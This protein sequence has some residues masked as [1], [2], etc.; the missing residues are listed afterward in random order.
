MRHALT[1]ALCGALGAGLVRAD[2]LELAVRDR[3]TD[4]P[5]PNAYVQVGP[6]P[7]VPFVGNWGFTNASGSLTLDHQA[8][9][10]GLPLTV[11]ASGYARL[12]VLSC[13]TGSLVVWCDPAVPPQ[14]PDTSRISG[15]VRGLPITHND[16]YLDVGV[17]MGTIAPAS[18][19]SGGATGVLLSSFMDTMHVGPPVNIDV[20]VPENIDIPSQYEFF[21]VNFFKEPYTQRFRTG[22]IVD[23]ICLGYRIN[24]NDL[25]SGSPQQIAA[26]KA[27]A[28]RDY[29]VS[30][31]ATVNHTCTVNFVH[32][33]TV[34]VGGLPPGSEGSVAS[35][36][37]LTGSVREDRFVPLHGVRCRADTTVSLSYLPPSGVFADV[38]AYAGV[39]YADTSQEPS[40]GGGAFDW[41]ALTPGAFRSFTSFWDPP[42]L[43]R[44]GSV[45]TIGGY[46]TPGTPPATWSVSRFVLDDQGPADQDSLVWE[47]VGPG[48]LT[49]F[50]LPVLGPGAPGWRVLPDPAQTFPDDRLMWTASVVFSPTVS[51]Q[52]FLRSP[53]EDAELF[54]FRRGEAP[55]LQPPAWVTVSAPNVG[56][57]LVTWAPVQGA[58]DY[59][60]G[61]GG[62][63]WVG[64][65]GVVFTPETSLLDSG[66]LLPPG[67]QRYY[68]VR[69]RAGLSLSVPTLP[70]GGR[71][72]VLDDGP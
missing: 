33:V 25:I 26:T 51:L 44:V 58:T 6:S 45:F 13:P 3:T 50:A 27:T 40:W 38:A 39:A 67:A 60:V 23:M 22:S 18:L 17:V 41:T 34:T 66:A 47:A 55:P 11:A 43:A 31:D 53:F 8:L 10:P 70:V 52:A 2:T 9:V 61:W 32:G 62:A 64:P 57:L 24:V 36:G 28:V 59:A 68:R 1:L 71:S 21:I 37:E 14:W 48:P 42:V 49:S 7:D 69:S 35:L 15:V 12:T 4:A 63:P 56:D 20:P 30:G 65:S 46:Q 19:L 54:S 16:G 72:W 5:L 29:V